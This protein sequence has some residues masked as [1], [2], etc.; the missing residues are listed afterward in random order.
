MTSIRSI[1]RALFLGVAI[2]TVHCG[3]SSWGFDDATL[4]IQG[5]GGGVGGGVKEKLTPNKPLS[6][7]VTLEASD[8]LKVLLTATEDRKPKRPHQAFLSIKDTQSGLETSYV[9]GVKDNGKAKTELTH[10]DI[11]AQLLVAKQPLEATLLIASFGSSKGFSSHAFDLNIALDPNTPIATPEKPLR[12][13]KLP[14][15][16]HIFRPDP[17]SPPKIVSIVFTAAVVATIPILLAVWLSLG[18]N[19]NHL[20][21]A[22]GNAPMSHTVFFGS[23]VA[24]EGIFFLYYTSW[25]LFQ[26]LPAVAGV[27]SIAFISG[28]RALSEVQERRLAGLR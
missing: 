19:L 18:A 15:I 6:K 4:T 28:S 21:Q 13:G 23:V 7:P 14:E 12:Y 24:L 1:L 2:G 5:K 8:S 22:L 17:Q 26:T 10:K 20:S 11:P 3:S 27:G 16:H 9:F 25:N